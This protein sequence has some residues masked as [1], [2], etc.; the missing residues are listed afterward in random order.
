MNFEE[1][2]EGESTK[3]FRGLLAFDRKAKELAK[4]AWLASRE[5]VEQPLALDGVTAE[6]TT[7]VSCPHCNRLVEIVLLV[8]PRK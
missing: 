4:A 7:N 6:R 3:D 8:S 2:L 1:W 5:A